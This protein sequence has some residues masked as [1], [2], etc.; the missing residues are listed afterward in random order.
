[1]DSHRIAPAFPFGFGL[2]YTGFSYRD[3]GATPTSDGAIVSATIT[4]GGSRAGAEVPQLYLGIPSRSDVPQP[5]AQ[6]KGFEKV[7]LQPGQSARVSFPIGP[8][9]LSYWDTRA[10]RWRVASGCYRVAV[11]SSSRDLALRGLVAVNGASCPGAIARVNA[12][13]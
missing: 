12:N 9:A 7:T 5:P 13:G 6:L 3:L 8:R 1:L 11:G 10:A 2:S 4:N